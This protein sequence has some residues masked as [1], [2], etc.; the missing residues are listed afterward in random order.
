MT[1]LLAILKK[2]I[3]NNVLIIVCSCI[4]F[5]LVELPILTNS[6]PLTC[7]EAWYSN[8]AY[9][10][11]QEHWIQNTTVGVG[12]DANFIYPFIQGILFLIF[13]YSIFLARFA[14]VLA[15]LFS[16]LVLFK[17]LKQLNIPNNATLFGLFALIAIPN[18]HSAF[19]YARPESWAILFVLLSLLFFIK[20]LKLYSIKNSLLSGLFC[21][22]GF[23]THPFTLS[24]SFAIGILLLFNSFKNKKIIPIIAFTLPLI[25]SA[26]VFFINDRFFL[27]NSLDVILA[28]VNSTASTGFLNSIGNNLKIIFDY[29]ILDKNV[30]YFIP[31]FFL[32]LAGLFMKKVNHLAFIS[33]LMG[34]LAFCFSLLFFSSYGFEILIIY[35]FIFSIVNIVFI[36]NTPQSKPLIIA[37]SIYLAIMLSANIFYDI[38]KYEP[39]NSSLEKELQTIIPKNAR[40][41]GPIAFW[42]FVP[43][44]QYKS[45]AYILY[46]KS[47]ITK[48]TSE[49]EYFL[50][51]SED[52]NNIYKE[53][54][55]ANQIFK[56]FSGSKLIYELNTKNYGK[57]ELYSIKTE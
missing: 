45:T 7:D 27:G 33:S 43:Q 39:V 8:S 21:A 32:L 50:L 35:I 57:V 20:Y 14:S 28:R 30:I 24:V 17:I 55:D 9:N 41:L 16:I 4:L 11:S 12:G 47:D 48:L 1:K 23:L 15:G 5:L 31:L 49:F 38:K 29:Y 19:R 44:T 40:V 13:G 26:V 3:D 18:Y 37:I 54:F 10:F 53:V 2:A 25:I 22:L 34:S 6:R 51:F 52:K 42:M 46:H 56:Q 36:A